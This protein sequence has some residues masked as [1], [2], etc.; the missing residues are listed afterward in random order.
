M[1]KADDSVEE[2]LEKYPG[3]NQFLMKKG[4]VCVK[5]GEPFWGRLGELIEAKG[6]N[7]EEIMRELNR[8]FSENKV[9]NK[10]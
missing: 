8:E 9:N 6:L 4:V 1:I 7:V 3:I 2:L 10:E 5:C